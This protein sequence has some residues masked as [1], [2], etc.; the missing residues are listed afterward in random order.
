MVK[1]A[2]RGAEE[3]NR[4]QTAATQQLDLAQYALYTLGDEL[5][6]VMAIPGRREPASVH[7]LDATGTGEK[8]QALAA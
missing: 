1:T 7:V 2:I 6:A 4:R 3:A 5:A 8:S